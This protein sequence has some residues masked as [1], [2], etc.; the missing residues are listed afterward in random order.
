MSNLLLYLCDRD[1]KCDN[2]FY[3][4]NNGQVKIGDLGL[5]TAQKG[6]SVVGT[7]EFMAPEIYNEE[8]YNEKVD[9]Y[10]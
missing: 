2:I 1:L 8:A 6:L 9:I 5:A 7:P 3:N 10:R 4:A